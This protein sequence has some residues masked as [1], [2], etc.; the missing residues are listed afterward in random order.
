VPSPKHNLMLVGGGVSEYSLPI[1]DDVKGGSHNRVL[2]TIWTNPAPA[3]R[4]A[5]REERE[6]AA[7][8]FLRAACCHGFVI[9][10]SP[11]MRCLV[12]PPG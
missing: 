5:E 1:A 10:H 7:R 9:E 12:L 8:W 2:R 6:N 4:D 11:F 3:L